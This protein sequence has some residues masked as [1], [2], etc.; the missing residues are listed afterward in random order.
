MKQLSFQIVD[1]MEISL[2]FHREKKQTPVLYPHFIC[3]KKALVLICFPV[4]VLNCE[5][6]NRKMTKYN[7]FIL[8]FARLVALTF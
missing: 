5:C 6:V 4:L 8:L 1:V 2:N 3:F 7:M